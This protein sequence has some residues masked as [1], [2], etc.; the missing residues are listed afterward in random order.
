MHH[1]TRPPTPQFHAELLVMTGQ[2]RCP[3]TGQDDLPLALALFD[4]RHPTVPPLLLSPTGLRDALA[5][6]LD[7]LTAALAQQDPDPGDERRP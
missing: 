4:R 2:W 1:R 5:R 7:D 3:L 6:G